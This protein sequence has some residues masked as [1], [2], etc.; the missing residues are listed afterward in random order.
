MKLNWEFIHPDKRPTAEDSLGPV[1]F[2]LPLRLLRIDPVCVCLSGRS[3]NE[4][5][6]K[7]ENFNQQSSADF[8]LAELN[9]SEAEGRTSFRFFFFADAS[10]SVH[11]LTREGRA[12]YFNR[13]SDFV[14]FSIAT[15]TL[16]IFLFGVDN[17]IDEARPNFDFCETNDGGTVFF[18][19]EFR[20]RKTF[21]VRW[22]FLYKKKKKSFVRCKV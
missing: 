8:A 13:K 11:E 1:I 15:P 22:K 16:I 20:W 5:K 17:W 10:V 6:N 2:L 14:P 4:I 19:H 3:R 21:W 12:P 18:L 9:L 7:C